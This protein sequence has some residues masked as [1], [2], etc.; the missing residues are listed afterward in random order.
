ML[1]EQSAEIHSVELITAENDVII[2]WPLQQ[3]AHV[4]ADRVCRAL[5]PLRSFRRL[6]CGEDIHEAARKII[7]LVARLDM[8]MQRHAVELR[9]HINRAQPRVKAV[10]DRYVDEPILPP[11]RDGR[12]RPIFG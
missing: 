8:A 7:E 5:I 1:V 12:F 6:L 2:E 4:L 3:V 10:T 11:K 9:Q